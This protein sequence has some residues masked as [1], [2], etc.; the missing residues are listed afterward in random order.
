M[1]KNNLLKQ[2]LQNK[3][4]KELIFQLNLVKPYYK[5]INDNKLIIEIIII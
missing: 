5:I 2:Q 1:K 4:D 3:L